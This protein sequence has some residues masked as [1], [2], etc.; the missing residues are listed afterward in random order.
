MTKNS[1]VY[2][3]IKDNSE[4]KNILFKT[5]PNIAKQFSQ[6]L[7]NQF[8][9]FSKKMLSYGDK[10]IS[11][12]GDLNKDED[13]KLALMGIWIRVSDKINRLKNLQIKEKQNPLINESLLDTWEDICNY[14]IIA[15][16]VMKGKWENE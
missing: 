9:L 1:D 13:V 12:G 2:P 11:L 15:K 3:K 16:I 5:Y 6:E 8:E 14:A 4:Y 10:N 7:D